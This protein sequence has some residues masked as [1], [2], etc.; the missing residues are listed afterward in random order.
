MYFKAVWKILPFTKGLRN[1]LVD[2]PRGLVVKNPVSVGDM[3]LIHGL[4]R[5]YTLQGSL[6]GKTAELV[7]WSR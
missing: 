6:C 2:F 3:G 4:G 7:L 1:A 5:F